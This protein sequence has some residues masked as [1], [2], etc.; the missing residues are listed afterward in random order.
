MNSLHNKQKTPRK[1]ARRVAMNNYK[2]S[3][4]VGVSAVSTTAALTTYE[5]SSPTVSLAKP[6]AMFSELSS[7]PN[8]VFNSNNMINSTVRLPLGIPVS[9]SMWC[10]KNGG[11]LPTSSPVG[12]LPQN[13]SVQTWQPNISS[14]LVY[15]N[16][17][18]PTSAFN[19]PSSPKRYTSSF[20]MPTANATRHL[21]DGFSSGQS[22]PLAGFPMFTTSGTKAS[23]GFGSGTPLAAPYFVPLTATTPLSTSSSTDASASISGIHSPL[24]KHAR[25]Y[26]TRSSKKPAATFAV[27]HSNPVAAAAAA[28]G[29]ATAKLKDLTVEESGGVITTNLYKEKESSSASNSVA[30]SSLNN[31]NSP[32]LKTPPSVP[33][34]DANAYAPLS[35]SV[36]ACNSCSCPQCLDRR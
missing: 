36:A 7:V 30:V 1:R 12:S 6:A 10:Q 13:T 5:L 14:N 16:G 3:T 2:P 20:G 23:T 26:A 31:V 33:L 18:V 19:Q 11:S 27:S 21:P 8:F 24:K 32:Q 9:S 22:A 28:V 34:I 17:L 4:S 35:N 29:A 15:S 25:R